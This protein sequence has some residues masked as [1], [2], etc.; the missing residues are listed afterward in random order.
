M[1]DIRTL[2]HEAALSPLRPLDMAALQTRARRRSIR[3]FATWVAGV[4][5]VIT[6]AVPTGGAILVNTSEGQRD[7]AERRDPTVE[8]GTAV[9]DDGSFQAIGG[10]ETGARDG[11]LPPDS[12][13][14]SSTT[15]TAS[16]GSGSAAPTDSSTYPR[17]SSCVVDNVG[18]GDGE[19]RACRFTATVAG[20]ADMTST[21]TTNPPPGA[22]GEV[23][24]TRDGVS[25]TYDAEV[26]DR[27]V[28]DAG[29]FAGCGGEFIQPG[30][31]VDVVLTNSTADPE[32]A[33]ITLGA[34]EGWECW[35]R[36]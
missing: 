32:D 2:L 34:G 25:R 31:L 36:S 33:T 3:R 6:A 8:D 35:R 16:G 21:G 24:V 26:T 7:R 27:R 12:V 19:T 29:V 22:R 14:R 9:D 20:S 5:V 30:D 15:T 18:L 28:G 23:T 10:G 13:G 1:T 4:G 17:R 11:G